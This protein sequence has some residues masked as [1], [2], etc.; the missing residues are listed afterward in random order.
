MPVA[1]PLSLFVVIAWASVTPS[2]PV[3]WV[4]VAAWAIGLITTVVVNVGINVRTARVDAGEISAAN[5]YAVRARWEWFQAFRSWAFL[6][7]FVL[8]CLAVS[9]IA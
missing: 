6:A 1:M 5:W 3:S 7:A 4:A 9:G 8:I 2:G